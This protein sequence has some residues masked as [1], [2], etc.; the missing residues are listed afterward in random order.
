MTASL[1][2]GGTHALLAT[3][4]ALLGAACDDVGSDSGGDAAATMTPRDA[5]A[6]GDAGQIDGGGAASDAG[7]L[8]D[9]A[10]PAADSTAA[11]SP[12][13]AEMPPETTD[14][15]VRDAGAPDA[16][17]ED[18]CPGDP[19]KVAPGVCGCGVTDLDSDDDGTADCND[20]CPEDAGKAG[21]GACGCGVA[22]TD[23]DSDGTADCIDACPDDPLASE[24]NACGVC[25]AA[26]VELCDGEDNDCD[27]ATDEGFGVGS[28]CSVGVGACETSGF[29]ACDDQGGASCDAAPGL[30]SPEVCNEIDDDC[31]GSVDEGFGLG[32]E[33]FEGV[34]GCRRAAVTVCDA[35]GGVE[36]GAIP[37]EP[38]PERCNDDVD[39]DCNGETDEP[40]AVDARAWYLDVDGDEYG[41]P[42]TEVIA[43]TRPGAV[44]RGGDCD[45]MDP[46]RH[47]NRL[48]AC[49][50]I[51][52]D[53]D[54][55]ADEHLPDAD[56]D[57]VPDCRDACPGN[58]FKSSEVG[59]C[60]C[61]A[62]DSDA[63]EDGVPA[64]LLQ[65]SLSTNGTVTT[66]VADEATGRVL[67]GGF[68]DHIGPRTGS[69]VV[70]GPDGAVEPGWPR[71]DGLVRAVAPDG[72]GGWY[73]GGRFSRV[74]GHPQAGIAHVRA[75]RT[76][77]AS[78]S[79]GVRGGGVTHIVAAFGAVYVAGD[80]TEIGGTRRRN[81]AAID[82]ETGAV[83]DWRPEP[84]AG[85]LCDE[86]PVSAMVAAGGALYIAGAFDWVG[87][88]E[89]DGIA[90]LDPETG[91]ATEFEGRCSGSPMAVTGG[92]LYAGTC[93]YRVAT[94]EEVDVAPPAVDGIV[95]STFARVA[96]GGIVFTSGDFDGAG[97]V[98]RRLLFGF[99]PDTASVT[100]FDPRPDRWVRPLLAGEDVLYAGGD[101]LRIGGAPRS[102][103]AALDPTTGA[104]LPWSPG[105]SGPVHA[106]ASVAERFYVGGDFTVAGGQSGAA[107]LADGATGVLIED[108]RLPHVDSDPRGLGVQAAVT[109]GAGGWYVGGSFGSI[110]GRS[111]P[112][113]ARVRADGTL[114]ASWHAGWV[115]TGRVRS[116]AVDE[117]RGRLLVGGDFERIARRTGG[118]ARLA[119]ADATVLPNHSGGLVDGQV[120]AVASDGAGGWF[121]GGD[122]SEV[123][124]LPRAH[125]AHI[126]ADGSVDPA[127]DPGASSPVHALEVA[128]GLVIAGGEFTRAGG[129]FR[130]GLVALDAATGA[131]AAWDARLTGGPGGT[132]ATV[133]TLRVAGDVVY[134]A[135]AFDRVGD[136]ERS[137]L[138][139]LDLVTAAAT[140][141]APE[142]V[143]V[144]FRGVITPG[145]VQGIDVFGTS[146]YI[147]GRFDRV[148]GAARDGLAVVDSESGE[149]GAW[150]PGATDA[151]RNLQACNRVIAR[152]QSVYLSCDRSL[153]AVSVATAD[154]EWALDVGPGGVEALAMDGDTLYVGGSL[155]R[156][157][158][159]PVSGVTS[160]DVVA[161]AVVEWQA[162]IWRARYSPSVQ[163]LGVSDGV[164]YV[165]GDFHAAGGEIRR[166]L[167][168][169]N[170]AT[171][172][173][174]DWAPE[175][176]PPVPVVLGIYGDSV[177]AAS[178]LPPNSG[179]RD[180]E[181]LELAT[182]ARIPPDGRNAVLTGGIAAIAVAG[183][184]AYVGGN[185]GLREVDLATGQ[186]TDWDPLP[187]A[188]PNA[189][190]SVRALAV[191][192]DVLYV[193][194]RFDR[195]GGQPRLNVAALSRDTGRATDWD[196][197]VGEVSALAVVGGRVHIGTASGYQVACRST[198]CGE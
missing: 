59:A 5:S 29:I 186:R 34:G 97:G 64:C 128:A 135:G 63:D 127:W 94:G 105:A 129:A 157:G 166:H 155:Q 91:L 167:A 123:G 111:R 54:G 106:L 164:V 44:L 22:D 80:F 193:G 107:V 12:D 28:R 115:I 2:R 83:L 11:S 133:S 143:N 16:G 147:T 159:Q 13:A 178:V 79:P 7:P 101:F 65:D 68:F 130:P 88:T 4:F 96:V 35:E 100:A 148:A 152:A 154:V 182:G 86:V 189:S 19:Q 185:N 6:S 42:D 23:T 108:V 190:R 49:D 120:L 36:C 73:I 89:R 137:G 50:A 132:D 71:V 92:V 20:A 93:A 139:A 187:D 15:D 124:G 77:D 57:A 116:M 41:D 31:D 131:V 27:T 38:M 162:G 113:L 195:Y 81:L 198:P 145:E 46:E 37:G 158:D 95:P 78:W 121:I 30:P 118:G 99:D 134:V 191:D 103:L 67:V 10:A 140:A 171:G 1:R 47:P 122:F 61:G 183:D 184:V 45:D 156:L 146:V 104:A 17:E 161:G 153:R 112:R 175:I 53:C 18:L 82:P 48:D 70:L 165:G 32:V 149:L 160:V 26:P 39:N 58:P 40:A 142:P 69:G 173:L 74:G 87:G 170:L 66:L 33:C 60:G 117:A 102:R 188:N 51:D 21:P 84:C 52:N 172:D 114:D 163:A 144:G 75:D 150:D 85:R 24:L 177:A 194:G 197:R 109:D 110:A 126:L 176:E 141:W 151:F 56:S 76:V 25:G 14:A 90:A 138:A 125:L 43:C 196:P 62:I 169:F 181:R 179:W 119:A 168:A 174:S 180:F 98:S 9:G 8:E 72:E 3:L 55:F 136:A 192:G